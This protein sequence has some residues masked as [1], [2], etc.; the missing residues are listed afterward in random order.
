MPQ[1]GPWA[2]IYDE[3]LRFEGLFGPKTGGWRL[4]LWT[5]NKMIC[6]QELLVL[7]RW[8]FEWSGV[9]FSFSKLTFVKKI[10]FLLKF[11]AISHQKMPFGT[12]NSNLV[13][14]VFINIVCDIYTIVLSEFMPNGTRNRHCECDYLIFFTYFLYFGGKNSMKMNAF[15]VS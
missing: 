10:T 6:I 12:Q 4:Y 1:N 11:C 9:T 7:P 13:N 14:I 2:A 15:L 8:M 3:N 5:W